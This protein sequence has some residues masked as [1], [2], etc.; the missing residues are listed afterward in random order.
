MQGFRVRTKGLPKIDISAL[1][2]V[3]F[4]LLLFYIVTTTFVERPGMKLDLPDANSAPVSRTE[5]VEVT[6]TK[7]GEIFLGKEH[8]TTEKLTEALK[9]ALA[10][11][12]SNTVVVSADR[13]VEHGIVVSVMD[14]ARGAG[15][16][17]L[18]V[19]TRQAD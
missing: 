8:V 3:V 9:G 13:K 18:V 6:I 14:A 12:E 19:A 5:D 16:K 15:A 4:L 2:D 17:G 7:T 11:T 1:I 10:D